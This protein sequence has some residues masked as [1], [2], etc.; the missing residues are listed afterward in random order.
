MPESNKEN[1]D[2]LA[3]I[4]VSKWTK[5]DVVKYAVEMMSVEL[6][7]DSEEFNKAWRAEGLNNE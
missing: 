3:E 4:I 2:K 5:E 1:G 7:L 6:Q